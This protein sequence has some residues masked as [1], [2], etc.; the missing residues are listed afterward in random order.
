MI[1]VNCDEKDLIIAKM[2]SED[3]AETLQGEIHYAVKHVKKGDFVKA[4]FPKDV[5]LCPDYDC[6]FNLIGNTIPEG[7]YCCV[8][9]LP[10]E[11]STNYALV[12]DAVDRLGFK[13][14][15]KNTVIKEF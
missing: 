13:P 15:K 6:T 11:K 10:D 14:F 4:S 1:N 8:I 3:G 12:K 2:V 9:V 5:E 7:M